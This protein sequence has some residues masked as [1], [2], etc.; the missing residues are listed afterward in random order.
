MKKLWCNPRRVKP[1]VGVCECLVAQSCQTPWDAMD[2]SPPCSC[3]SGFS[4]QEQRWMTMPSF[5]GSSQPRSP[6]L[7]T[8]SFPVWATRKPS[9]TSQH[10][11]DNSGTKRRSMRVSSWPRSVQRVP[12]WS[13]SAQL[14]L[15]WLRPSQP[16]TQACPTPRPSQAQRQASVTRS[17]PR[18]TFVWYQGQRSLLRLY[19]TQASLQQIPKSTLGRCGRPGNREVVLCF[20]FLNLRLRYTPLLHIRGLGSPRTFLFPYPFLDPKS[21]QMCP[22]EAQGVISFRC[23]I[24]R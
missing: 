9:S 4:R 8:D 22:W 10:W 19:T 20:I 21:I 14:G 12:A 6:S 2:F 17:A 13:L 24:L 18:W 23:K 11:Q 5:R 1:S 3:P 16:Q 7:Q 15:A